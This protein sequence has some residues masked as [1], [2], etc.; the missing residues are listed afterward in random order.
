MSD[1]DGLTR[2]ETPPAVDEQSPLLSKH[3][4]NTGNGAAEQQ[5][6]DQDVHGTPIAKEPSTKELVITLCSIWV[7]VFLAALDSTVIATLSAPISTSFNSFT[8]LSWLA[9]A[10]LIANAALQPLAGR[11]TDIFSRRAGLIFSNIFFAA[12]NL[13]CGLAKSEWVIIL[14][15]IVAGM[16]GGGLFAISTFVASDLVPL[17]KRGLWQGFGNI[18]F[19]L[20]SGLGGV[21]GGWI[22]DVWGWRTAFLVQVPFVVV[23]GILVCFTVHI[24]VKEKNVSR[25]K[26]VDFLGAFTLVV[27]L[28]LLLLGLN[29]GGNV[30]PWTHPLVL[31][32]L[33]LSAVFLLIFIYVE[34]KIASEP[35]IPV[36]LLLNRTV[37][38]A[39]LT[40]W[41]TTMS[42]FALL[43]YGPIYFQVRGLSTTGA[44]ARLIPQSVG[45]AVGSLGSGLIMRATGRYWLLN[46]ITEGI[47]VLSF[48]LV[49]ATFDLN[50][51]AVPP[52]IYFFL[53]GL[54]YGGMLTVTLLAL[55]SAVDHEHQAVITSASYAFRSTG[56]TIGITIASAVFQN[57]LKRELWERFG[58][59]KDAAEIIGRVRD[60]LDEVK[61][62]PPEWK[63]GVL[64]TYMDALR[65]VWWT[66]LG[67]SLLGALISLLMRE[68]VL[69]KN[70][71]RR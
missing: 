10:Y 61:H 32:S 14:G 36:R 9:S 43:Y 30:V 2:Y 58:S 1:E 45:A 71:A 16:G 7:G 4:P 41:F 13:I 3:L 66:M 37:A 25:I 52:F 64:E 63:L 60:S 24:P 49:A 44:G 17:R 70:L 34:D 12:G 31:T 26:R 5:A 53:G 40:N 42:V 6:D 33:P 20:G 69:H 46:A 29:S 51:P 38:S 65:A 68:H 54:G 56:S 59:R 19:G 21:F 39:C 55:I 67:I 47:L 8:L 48:A 15:R 35:I 23:S 50:T 22:N 62:L 18:C 27:T 28:V 57:V 11:L